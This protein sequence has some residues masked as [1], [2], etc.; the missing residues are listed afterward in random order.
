MDDKIVLSTEQC[1]T[2]GSPEHEEMGGKRHAYMSIVGAVLWL[3]NVT[4]FELSYT[5]SQLARFVSN[6][7]E[8]HFAAAVRA[9]LYL[10]HAQHRVLKYSPCA[11]RPLEVYVDSNWAVKFSAS[12]ALFFYM[13]C[14]VHW[15]SKTQRSVAFSSA[16]SEMFGAILAAKEHDD[17]VASMPHTPFGRGRS[18]TWQSGA[19]F[20]PSFMIHPIAFSC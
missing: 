11:T 9:L 18:A 14:L 5:A 2:V 16:E 15:F 4:L 7:G 20:A 12:G 8:L 1:P 13:G 19:I 10:K 3:S 6:P 17:V